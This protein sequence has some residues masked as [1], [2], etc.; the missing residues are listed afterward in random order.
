MAALLIT[1]IACRP[2]SSMTLTEISDGL[3]PSTHV[4]SLLAV[5]WAPSQILAGT[6]APSGLYESDDPEAAWTASRLPAGHGPVYALAATKPPSQHIVAGGEGGIAVR[7]HDGAWQAATGLP[8]AITIYAIACMQDRCYAGGTSNTLFE[9]DDGRIWRPA[10]E[11]PDGVHILAIHATAGQILVGTNGQG[12]F[13]SQ[14]DG[15]RWE[16]ATEI[17]QTHVARLWEISGEPSLLFAR[18]RRGLF[19]SS[20]AG[21]HWEP[22]ATDIEARIDALAEDPTQNVLFLATGAGEIY[23]SD[24]QGVR[25]QRWGSLPRAGLV[26]ALHI[27]EG[28]GPWLAATEHGLAIS[29]DAGQSWSLAPQG[30]GHPMGFAMVRLGDGEILLGHGQGIARW[31]PGQQTWEPAD[32]GLPLV[33]VLSLSAAPSHPDI[34]YAGTNGGGVYRSDDGGQ[35][36]RPAGLAGRAI[37]DLAVH[38]QDP[39]RV[40]ARMAF[41]RIYETRD[42]GATW[43]ARWEG[44][45]LSVEVTRVAVHPANPEV[46]LA[47]Y[48]EGLY[49]SQDGGA[50]WERVDVPWDGLTTFDLVFDSARPDR[51]YAGTTRGIYITDDAGETWHLDVGF[52]QDKTVTALGLDGALYAGTHDGLLY[53]KNGPDGRWR[54]VAKIPDAPRVNDILPSSQP[55]AGVFVASSAGM[56]KLEGTR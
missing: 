53:A 41:E 6:L 7:G 33:S 40:Y 44:M 36:W 26:Q 25:W 28:G 29:R 48:V 5:P 10:S 20:D 27:P 43:H 4:L 18:T 30:P 19:R 16:P 54:Q 3:P 8:E 9:S 23:R 12:L 56:W 51:A 2:M 11:L 21:D 52:P 49:R 15:R 14:D 37:P 31:I 42:G 13:R 35:T 22:T 38:P 24:D 32:E 39:E 45:D 46:V 55:A 17:G 1:I 34:L 50:T 47:G